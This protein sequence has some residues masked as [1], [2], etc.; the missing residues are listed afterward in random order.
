MAHIIR[1]NRPAVI[2]PKRIAL[3]VDGCVGWYDADNATNA[4]RKRNMVSG[5]DFPTFRGTHNAGHD[6]YAGNGSAS[7]P[8]ITGIMETPSFSVLARLRVSTGWADGA[9]GPSVARTFLTDTAGFT[10]RAGPTNLSV[11]LNNYATL[12]TM[13]HGV[14]KGS[15]LDAAITYDNGAKSLVFYSLNR[16]LTKTQ[17]IATSRSVEPTRSV[18]IGDFT[19]AAGMDV[20]HISVYSRALS[21]AELRLVYD[22]SVKRSEA[23]A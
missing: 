15:W 20:K 10:L 1:T 7:A 4:A 23:N 2:N 6:T 13:A 5:A 18:L 19:E 9:I 21:L 8:T 12:Y 3:P 17:A 22:L 14:A 11:Y 16:G